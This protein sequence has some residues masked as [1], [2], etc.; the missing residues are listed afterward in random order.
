MK[1]SFRTLLAIFLVLALVILAGFAG[2]R[3]SLFQK[4][5]TE[6]KELLLEKV[7][8]VVKLGTV[9]GVFSEIYNYSDYYSYNISPLRKKA[10]IR[11]R[12]TVLVGFN[13]DSLDVN[14][15][16]LRQEITIRDLPDPEIISID[17]DLDYYDITEGYFNSF[18]RE[19][20]NRL[21]KQSKD[22]IR[23]KALESELLP[24]AQR[25]LEQNLELLNWAFR[26]AGWTIRIIERSRK[27]LLN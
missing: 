25:Q 6:S 18:S 4:H 13:L 26:E 2:Y 5:S 22:F 9:E 7:R 23:K 10:L 8:H 24:T 1:V 3:F 20:Y 15:D 19:D 16:Y 14:I 11:I 27:D 12:A 21:Q 17:H